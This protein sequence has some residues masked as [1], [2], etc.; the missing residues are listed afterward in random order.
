MATLIKHHDTPQFEE[1]ELWDLK[2]STK[3]L[4]M[5]RLGLSRSALHLEDVPVESGWEEIGK[6]VKEYRVL[7]DS[8]GSQLETQRGTF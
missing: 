8:I 4:N 5:I 2:V 7:N 6:T 1:F 3:E